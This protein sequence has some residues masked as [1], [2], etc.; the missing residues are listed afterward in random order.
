MAVYH[1]Q[2]HLHGLRV[3]VTGGG[4]G[5]HT[6]PA[7]TTIRTLRQRLAEIGAAPERLWVGVAHG[8]EAGV[9]RAEQVPFRAVTTGKLRRSPT[10]RELAHNIHRERIFIPWVQRQRQRDDLEADIAGAAE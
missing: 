1:T 10:L 4:T 9:A 2:Q 8:L 7:L 5:G 6:Y 3:I